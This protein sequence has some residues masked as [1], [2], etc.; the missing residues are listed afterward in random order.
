MLVLVVSFGCSAKQTYQVPPRID[1]TQHDVIGIIEIS[2]T[3][4][5]ELGPL[6]TRRLMDE[7][8][9]D[10]G[11]VRIV[12][13]GS[14]AEALASVG[15]LRLDRETLKAIGRK[16]GLQTILMGEL[17]VSDI[18]P[19]LRISS[20][21]DSGSVTARVDASLAVQLVETTSGAS[22]WSASARATDSVGH[23]SVFRGGHFVFD[24]Q[25]PEDAY[26]GLVDSLVSR[27]TSDF[28]VSWERR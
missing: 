20:L 17:T 21:L 7:A 23:I 27:A 4:K 9:R 19:D 8:R 18:K 16:H 6:A 2:T 5:G 26:G 10:Q 11:L 14:E 1:L 25:D 15:G 22:I 12:A 28:Q 24:A 3:A 13:L